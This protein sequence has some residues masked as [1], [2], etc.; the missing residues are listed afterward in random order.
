TVKVFPERFNSALAE[1]LPLLPVKVTESAEAWP[2]NAST[3]IRTNRG[4]QTSNLKRSSF[5]ALPFPQALH[6]PLLLVT[7]QLCLRLASLST[8][9]SYYGTR[10]GSALSTPPR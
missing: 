5:T 9:N 3:T 4:E 10:L 7:S 1:R 8:R 2:A 6:A